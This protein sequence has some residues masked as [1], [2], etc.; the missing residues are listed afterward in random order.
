MG[1]TESEAKPVPKEQYYQGVGPESIHEDTGKKIGSFNTISTS[2]T[3]TTYL[4]KTRPI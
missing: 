3:I 2:S 4:K 1:P